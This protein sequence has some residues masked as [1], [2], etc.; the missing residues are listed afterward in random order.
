MGILQEFLSGIFQESLLEFLQEILLRPVL[1]FLFPRVSPDN[2]PGYFLGFHLN[3]LLGFK[4]F[5]LHAFFSGN[6]FPAVL[7]RV[8][9]AVSTGIHLCLYYWIPSTYDG[10]SPEAN[11][12]YLKDFVLSLKSF[13]CQSSESFFWKPFRCSFWVLSRSSFC[14]SSW[15]LCLSSKSCF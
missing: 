2:L 12:E 8:P 3:F 15:V 7:V 5:R 14:K 13:L 10:F 11:L 1:V 9:K 6:P 4:K